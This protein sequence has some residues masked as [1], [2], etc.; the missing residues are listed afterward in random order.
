MSS[1][2][3]DKLNVWSW[4]AE[5]VDTAAPTD[6][7]SWQVE[8]TYPDHQLVSHGYEAHQPMMARGAR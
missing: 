6:G 5:Y 2:N 3:L 8:L 7:Y 1:L 4:K